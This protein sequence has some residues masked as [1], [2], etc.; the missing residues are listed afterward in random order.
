M[1]GERDEAAL[2]QYVED[3]ARLYADW[4]FPR[5]AAR[6]LMQLMATDAG[7]LTAKELSDGL[8]ISPAAVSQ[9]VRYLQ[10]LGLVE[11]SAVPGSRRDRYK[12]P[13]DA[14]YLGSIVKG[15]L[16][17]QVAKLA[18]GGVEAAG[19][20]TTP[21]G[22]RIAAMGDFYE[23]IQSELT[24]LLERYLKHRETINDSEQG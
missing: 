10:H 2:R 15:T 19:G 23:F 11:R 8:E 5:M 16:F 20:R 12:L 1:A 3:M 6:V 21:A 4:G 13:D 18:E 17:A 7:S 24:G 9:S 14:W 22:D